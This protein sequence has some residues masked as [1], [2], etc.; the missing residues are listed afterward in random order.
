MLK[1][2]IGAALTLLGVIGAGIV[3]YCSQNRQF[4]FDR[5]K[6]SE[7]YKNLLETLIKEIRIVDKKLKEKGSI[8]SEYYDVSIQNAVIIKLLDRELFFKNSEVFDVIRRLINYLQIL[9]GKIENYKLIVRKDTRYYDQ[10]VDANRAKSQNE[11]DNYKNEIKNNI[12]FQDII[13][14][15]KNIKNSIK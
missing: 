7:I 8:F 14:K 9:N 3:T 4:S 13:E 15:L 1:M 11:V 5:K 6:Q 2:A 10:T 12:N